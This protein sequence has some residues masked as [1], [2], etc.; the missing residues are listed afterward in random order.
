VTKTD[1]A[2]KT[3]SQDIRDNGKVRMG[4]ISPSFPSVYAVPAS[5]TDNS[6]VRIGTISPSFPPVR[7]R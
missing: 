7:A 2:V 3:P 4:T 1:I 6:R 5:V